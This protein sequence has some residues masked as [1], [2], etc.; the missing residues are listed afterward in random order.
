MISPYLNFER[1]CAGAMKLYQA[2]FGAT[3]VN[4]TTYGDFPPDSGFTVSEADKKLIGH[5]T[6]DIMGSTVM[7]S[8]TMSPTSTGDNVSLCA[9]FTDE[10]IA[11]AAWAKLRDGGVVVEEL[12]PVFFAKL[13]GMVQD[14]YGILWMF[15]VD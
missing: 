12:G 3:V 7:C 14:K 15:I 8:D 5:A 4:V 13:Y 9:G 1:S 6:L 10:G 2:A 11:R